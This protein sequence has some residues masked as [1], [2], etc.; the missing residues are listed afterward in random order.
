MNS[1]GRVTGAGQGI[2]P[3]TLGW[4]RACVAAAAII[5]L[6]VAGCSSW[7]SIDPKYG[8]SASPRVVNAGEPVPRGGGSYKVGSPYRVAGRTYVPANDPSYDQVGLASWYGDAFHGRKTANG[9]VFDMY[10][11]SAAH[12]TLPMP[13]YVRVTN[14]E[15]DRSVVVRVNDRGPFAHNRVI[16]L[17]RR[18]AEVLGFTHQGTAKV[19]VQYVGHAPLDGEDE[20]L[21]TTVTHDGRPVDP[22]VVASTGAPVRSPQQ[23]TQT[24]ATRNTGSVAV[25]PVSFAATNATGFGSDADFTAAFAHFDTPIARAEWQLDGR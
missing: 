2:G 23:P 13:T 22:V 18:T 16:D 24:A 14:L 6:A 8:V 21:T 9:E 25:I 5:G 7:S 1:G 11:L 12:P 17:S 10:A 20:W 4:R 3:M 15:N 19:R